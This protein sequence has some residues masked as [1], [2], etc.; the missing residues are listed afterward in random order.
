[1]V[2]VSVSVSTAIPRPYYAIQ[3]WT[4]DVQ[5]GSGEKFL[6]PGVLIR[7]PKLHLAARD[8]GTYSTLLRIFQHIKK[9]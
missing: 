5:F 8:K 3:Y 1:M 4:Q 2:S 7:I 6:H 9:V